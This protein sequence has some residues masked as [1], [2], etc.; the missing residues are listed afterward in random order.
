MGHENPP[1][2]Y[3]TVLL[4]AMAPACA[5]ATW[6]EK[7]LAETLAEIEAFEAIEADRRGMTGPAL[8]EAEA[9][10]RRTA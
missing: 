6:D 2:D 10:P 9:K 5:A 7:A 4:P 3:A 1:S 8:S